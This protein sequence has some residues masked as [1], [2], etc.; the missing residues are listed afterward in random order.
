[1][2][3]G[4][5]SVGGS[6]K[7]VW[8]FFF[9]LYFLGCWAA[10]HLGLIVDLSLSFLLEICACA[11][12]VPGL[13]ARARFSGPPTVSQSDNVTWLVKSFFLARSAPFSSTTAR[14]QKPS[15]IAYHHH[16]ILH[17]LLFYNSVNT[18]LS[19][20]IFQMC[21]NHSIIKGHGENTKIGGRW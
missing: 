18:I 17:R 10:A 15:Q 7:S 19:L 21:S 1:M 9:S 20:N 3:N 16:N 12:T 2:K 5:R 13:P 8:L 6:N 4:T 14:R 11:C